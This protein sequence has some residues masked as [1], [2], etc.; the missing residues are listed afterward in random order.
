MY[1]Y[2]YALHV[3]VLLVCFCYLSVFVADHKAAWEDLFAA[4]SAL[5]DTTLMQL[6]LLNAKATSLMYCFPD[7]DRIIDTLLVCPLHVYMQ[8][9]RHTYI[10]TYI[11]AYIHT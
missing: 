3:G 8:T 6:E 2:L 7:C 9:E 4:Y 5:C 1:V 10:H 11:H